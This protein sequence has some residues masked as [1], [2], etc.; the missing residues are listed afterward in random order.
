[1][2]DCLPR[3]LL[4]VVDKHVCVSQRVVVFARDVCAQLT[5]MQQLLLLIGLASVEATIQYKANGREKVGFAR[6]VGA[7]CVVVIIIVDTTVAH[8]TI[9]IM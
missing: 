9:V 7:D 4:C 3:A 5:H 6:P 1:M 2:I 8:S